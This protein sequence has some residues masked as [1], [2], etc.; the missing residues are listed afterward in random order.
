[1]GQGVR[2]VHMNGGMAAWISR[3]RGVDAGIHLQHRE[4]WPDVRRRWGSSWSSRPPRRRSRTA[5]QVWTWSSKPS[6]LS[7]RR[8]TSS[9]PSVSSHRLDFAPAVAEMKLHVSVRS[10][11]FKKSRGLHTA[12]PY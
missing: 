10:K 5:W 2:A 12:S 11:S 9:A 1:V 7:V 6:G 8:A 3:R 4:T